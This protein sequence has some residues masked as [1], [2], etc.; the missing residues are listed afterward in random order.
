[1]DGQ[2]VTR[3]RSLAARLGLG[4][5]EAAA[6]ASYDWANS[7]FTTTVVAAVFPIYDQSVVSAGLPGN[8]ASVYFGYTTAAGLTLVAL[9]SPVLGA[10]ADHYRAKKRLLAGVVGANVFYDSLF[11]H[12]EADADRLSTAG[13][14]LGYPGGG[15]L[16]LS[17][18]DVTEGRRRAREANRAGAATDE[19]PISGAGGAAGSGGGT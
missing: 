18:V 3:V 11:S 14:A 2:V 13:Y 7:A 15:A 10:I 9:V 8:L 17:R 6:W 12:V 5:R 19:P 4:S 16:V 1:M